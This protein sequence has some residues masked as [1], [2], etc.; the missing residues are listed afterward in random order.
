M[1]EKIA[2]AE[3]LL[4]DYTKGKYAFGTGCIDS[5]GDFVSEFGKNILL[6]ISPNEWAKALREKIEKVLN[7]KRINIV[8]RADTSREN[9]PV[10]DVFALA[11]LIRTSKP[12]CI[13]CVGG[14]SAIDTAKASNVL[15]SL[16]KDNSRIEKYFGA[17]EVGKRMQELKVRNL[18]PFIAVQVASGSGS[19]ISKYANITD[20]RTSQKKLIIDEE[21]VPVRA[22]FDYSFTASMPESLT[23]DGALD[24]FS[25]CLEVYYGFD[26]KNKDFKLVEQVCL[27]GI[28]LIVENL[29][30]LINDLEDVGLREKIGIATDLGGYAIMLYG[31]NGAHLNSFS[32]VDILPHGRACAILNPYY[33]V[34]FTPSI[35]NKL[36]KLAPIYQEYSDKDLSILKGKK[37]GIEIA[38]AMTEF[39]RTIGFPTALSEVKGFN[40]EHIRR[41]V[42]AAKNPQLESKLKNMPVPITSEEVE[43]YIKP[44]LEAAKEG[45]FG[46]IK[47]RE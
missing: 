15:A 2:K 29:P 3:K 40:D 10:E 16:E 21:I 8:A 24:G 5:L 23:K 37:L 39:S 36:R 43:L 1:D 7:D 25:H 34:F 18:Y 19:H 31:T 20:L 28:S 33:T 12:E 4:K 38:R 22:V 46:K 44:V 32:F 42:N 9:S 27:T 35:E 17:G 14:G 6:I 30:Y 13:V 45:D 47:F 41:A 26:E 11:D